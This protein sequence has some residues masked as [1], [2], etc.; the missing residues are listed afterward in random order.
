MEHMKDR[1][2]IS[3][4]F[5]SIQQYQD[6]VAAI[7][8]GIV[9]I[10]VDEEGHPIR[11][12]N[13]GYY[14]LV[15][16]EREEY[17]RLVQ[18][19]VCRALH[20][21]EAEETVAFVRQQLLHTGAFRTKACLHHKTKGHI[22]A[23]LSGRLVSGTQGERLVYVVAVDASGH[24][25]SLLELERDRSFKELI[26][27][28][29]D[30]AFFDCDLRCGTI[31]CSRDLADRLGAEE[32]SGDCQGVLARL[33]LPLA[34]RLADPTHSLKGLWE[35]EL[36]I[37]S[38]G[39]ATS[40]YRCRSLVHRDDAG[41]PVRIV[42]QLVDI[43]WHKRQVDALTELAQRDQLTGLY[44][45]AATESR[46]KARLQMRRS[47]DT[48]GA[49]LII[50]VDDFKAVNDKLGHLYGDAVL[51][52]L[53]ENLSALFRSDDIV[54]RVGGDE[55]F[56]F[57]QNY[58]TRDRLLQKV[59]EIRS[60]FQKTFWEGETFVTISASIGIALTP[61]HDSQ[62]DGL[63]RKADAAL[64]DAKARGK[65]TYSIYTP[66]LAP[67]YTATRTA[68][69]SGSMGKRFKDN[70]I[71]YVFRLLYNSENPMLSIQTVLQ[72]VT[73]SYGFSR[74]Y[75]FETSADGRSTSNT[76]EWCAKGIGAEIENL[77]EIPIEAV[78]T[79]NT[80]F[81][82]TGMFIL[83][84]LSALPEIE[85]AVLEPQGILSMFQFGIKDMGKLI[86]FI[87]FDDCIQERVPTEAEI[88]EICTVCH[89]LATFL[90]RQRSNERATRHHRAI[91]TVI[92]HMNSLAYVIDMESY[93]VRYENQNVL[94][95]TGSPSVG[96][97]CHLAYRG[98]DQPC[99]DCPLR[100]MSPDKPKHVME[101]Y[102]QKY[103]LHVRTEASYIDW[104]DG[105]RACLICSM[106]ISEYKN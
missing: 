105:E 87:G 2:H 76:F 34:E 77:Q 45:K 26:E 97:Q 4:T 98:S 24:L 52:Q 66:E 32:L 69:D 43:T 56:V 37:P 70:R 83:R 33:G 74:G 91:E 95:L 10:A 104:E 85:R 63:Y 14:D 42:G 55:F 19:E 38:P 46:I 100:A 47:S 96:Q 81:E 20:P 50:D 5:D 48:S 11:F 9:A 65:N 36:A 44:H 84:S 41:A 17:A 51:T 49:L 71:E 80:N 3:L 67:V 103:D 8:G 93:V 72:L 7:P 82:R 94:R 53:A 102:N 31:R 99:A 61:D 54:G 59:E 22:S 1:G 106:D 79:A 39:G 101:I 40:W 13:Q 86:G 88:D 23:Y 78:N 75:I 89:V 27:A 57:M 12:A 16:F 92:D 15:G 60:H 18:N 73:E 68:I 28:L 6:M 58:R 90:L 25:D 62:F 21:D 30:E 64:Y 29:S 35:D